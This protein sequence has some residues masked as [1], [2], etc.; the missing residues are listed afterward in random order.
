MAFSRPGFFALHCRWSSRSCRTFFIQCV[1]GRPGICPEGKGPVPVP[2]PCCQCQCQCQ[3]GPSLPRAVMRALAGRDVV[4]DRA[5]RRE[6][7][8]QCP[9]ANGR[10]DMEPKGYFFFYLHASTRMAK[11][12]RNALAQKSIPC[13]CAV[14]CLSLSRSKPCRRH[15]VGP[16]PAAHWPWPPTKIRERRQP[17]LGPCR[18]GRPRLFCSLAQ[19]GRRK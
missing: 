5:R 15:C 3:S 14:S 12:P 4:L 17:G 19:N 13:D 2:A 6:P 18:G 8:T 7:W 16:W 1:R 10:L 11:R 9:P